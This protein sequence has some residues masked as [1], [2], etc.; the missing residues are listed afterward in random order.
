MTGAGE[1]GAW[2]SFRAQLAELGHD[3]ITLEVNT[4]IKDNMSARPVPSIP[5]A[6]VEIAN[7]YVAVFQDLGINVSQVHSHDPAI[8][9][10]TEA[11]VMRVEA[12]GGFF[13]LPPQIKFG[14]L[15][16]V[17]RWSARNSR[18]AFAATLSRADTILLRR[19][20]DNSDLLVAILTC[21]QKAATDQQ[22]GDRADLKDQEVSLQDI[23]TRE[24]VFHPPPPLTTNQRLSIRKIWE[25]GT[26]RVIAQTVIH[27][28]GDVVTRIARDFQDIAGGEERGEQLLSIHQLGLQTAVRQWKALADA[29]R[30]VLSAITGVNLQAGTG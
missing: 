2:D 12:G 26:E 22:L 24:D 25:V 5:N 1:P 10:W 18:L 13:D 29:G 7:S 20:E 11:P 15:F 4:I 14:R 17:L 27:L 19:I 3:L 8:R 28:D 23:R 16:E 6:L 21:A 30:A 9:P